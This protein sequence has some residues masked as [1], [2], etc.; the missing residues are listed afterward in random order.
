[1]GKI[2][3]WF[4]KAYAFWISLTPFSLLYLRSDCYFFLVYHLARYRRKVVRDNLVKSFP[5]KSPQEIKQIEKHFYHN[6]CDVFVETCKLMRVTR[7]ELAKHVHFTN[8]EMIQELYDRQKSVFAAIPHSGNWEWF[9]KLL[10]LASSHKALG[11][12]K[13]VKDPY[14]DAFMIDLRTNF[15]IDEETVIESAV[16]LKALVR[17]RNLL[18][19]VLI[20]A[21]QSPRGVES[22]YWTEFLHR[23]TCWFYGLE[24]MAKLLDYAVVFV[25]M[26]RVRRG[27]Y[28]VTFHKIC[29]DPKPMPEG[30][31]MEQYVRH[32]ERFIQ[33]NPDN[34]LWSHRRWK[35][36]RN[37]QQG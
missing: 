31:I 1:M 37:T 29:D 18:N 24:R 5:E 35:H 8:P 26:T 11:I 34:W 30:E 15:H 36:S 14:F 28:E 20:V 32:V 19:S 13:K 7:D 9:G 22:D 6:L 16:A 25:D 12:Y 33:D 10:H 17:R 27:C 23:D 2:G 4:V 3:F 21:D